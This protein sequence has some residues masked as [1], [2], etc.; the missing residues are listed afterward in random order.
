MASHASPLKQPGKM[1]SVLNVSSD[2]DA[3]YFSSRVMRAAGYRVMESEGL[4]DTLHLLRQKPDLLVLDVRQD[5]EGNGLH[6]GVCNAI[7]QGDMQAGLPILRLTAQGHEHCVSPACLLHS[8]RKSLLWPAGGSEL[9]AA[10]QDLVPI[11]HPPPP[12]VV[13]VP[14]TGGVGTKR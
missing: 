11:E 2:V 3:L 4:L 9:L 10:V 8:R 13:A 14:A 12:A 1:I 6:C 5:N 7:R